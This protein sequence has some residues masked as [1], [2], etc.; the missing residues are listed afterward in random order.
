MIDTRIK[1][2]KDLAVIEK[3]TDLPSLV[4]N[5]SDMSKGFF[6]VYARFHNSDLPMVSNLLSQYT[7]DKDNSRLEWLD[8]NHGI[9]KI[10]DLVTLKKLYRTDPGQK[11]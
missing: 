3:L 5:R 4:I 6:Y 2:T 7:P 8:P 10:A 11:L 9:M 1:N